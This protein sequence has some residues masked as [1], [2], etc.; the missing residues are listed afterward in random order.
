MKL[1]HHDSCSK[2]LHIEENENLL[3][4]HEQGRAKKNESPFI[5]FVQEQIKIILSG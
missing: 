3:I 2:C 1:V 5:L 4:F